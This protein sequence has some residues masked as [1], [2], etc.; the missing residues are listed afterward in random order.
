MAAETTTAPVLAGVMA[1][2]R[3]SLLLWSIALSA[4]A[5]LY[6]GVYPAIGADEMA[7]MVEGLP[8]GMA[9]AFGY[10]QMASAG[11]YLSST[12]YGLL[13]PVLLLVFA[14]ATGTRL[15]AGQE[16]D[17]VL[18][19]EFT[20]PV[21]RRRVYLERLV[22]LW[23]NVAILVLVLT[24]VTIAL[25][26][27]FELD[28][29]LGYVAGGSLGLLLLVVGFATVGLA[30]GAATGRR[31]IGLGVAAG[32]AVLAFMFD[33][34]GP[35]IDAGWMTAVSPF[36]WFLEDDPLLQ[37]PDPQG[38]ALLAVV[39]L[40]AAVAGLAAFRRRDLMT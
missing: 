22:A 20:A 32:L 39:P 36:S 40:V 34:I 31:V 10:D 27:A 19:L 15:L 17:G 24:V 37:G 11:G 8:E 25:V 38:Y 1:E 21:S 13:G 26:L 35:T 33:A 7:A 4:V 2:Q 23:S 3:R 29:G 30:V 14:I 12:I 18:E 28:V 9:T 16:E 6:I 5:L